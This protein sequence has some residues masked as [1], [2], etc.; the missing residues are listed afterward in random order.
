MQKESAS[1][2]NRCR[3]SD[4]KGLYNFIAGKLTLELKDE[5]AKKNWRC[6]YPLGFCWSPILVADID[7]TSFHAGFVN[8]E[9]T[10]KITPGREFER[11][12]KF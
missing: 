1:T 11:N 12:V 5:F 10:R 7:H 6:G 8:A 2:L 9:V 3:I 4:R